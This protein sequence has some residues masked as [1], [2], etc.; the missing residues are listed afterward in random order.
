MIAAKVISPDAKLITWTAKPG[1]EAGA[2]RVQ[3]VWFFTTDREGKAA[4]YPEKV[5]VVLERAA[6]GN[7]EQPAYVPGDYQLHPSSFYIRD[8]RLAVSPRLT[9][10]K[11]AT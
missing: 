7:P 11:R 6:N 8:G 4:P 5:E 2:M 3:E 1:R 10:V 9:P